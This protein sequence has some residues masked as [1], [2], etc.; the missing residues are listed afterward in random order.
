MWQL[1]TRSATMTH[2]HRHIDPYLNETQHGRE[3]VRWSYRNR[4]CFFFC[5]HL[6]Y[7]LWMMRDCVCAIEESSVNFVAID[8]FIVHFARV[9]SLISI[10]AVDHSLATLCIKNVTG[11][12]KL[13][14]RCGLWMNESLLTGGELYTPCQMKMKH[15]L[16]LMSF[17]IQIVDT[18]RIYACCFART[19]G[20][21]IRLPSSVEK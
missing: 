15:S 11:M 5:L 14:V 7:N 21:V 8:V 17:F 16:I 1:C 2:H 20:V 9:R 10:H 18:V 6:S 3:R 12:D 4:M 19:L 13:A